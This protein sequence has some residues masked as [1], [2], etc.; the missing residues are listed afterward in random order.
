MYTLAIVLI[1]IVCLLLVLIVLVQKSKGGGLASN[2]SGNN[3]I[4]GVRRTADF[5]EKATWA[6]AGALLFLCIMASAFVE[7]GQVSQDSVIM[8]KVQTAVDPSTDAMFPTSPEAIE[9]VGDE[10]A[11]EPVTE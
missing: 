6:L 4:M 10:Q 7:R 5:L 9:T 11:E 8:N 1:F 2:F 3:Q